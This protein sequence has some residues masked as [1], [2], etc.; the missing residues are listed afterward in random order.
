[1]ECPYCSNEL[2]CDDYYG[3]GIPGRTGFKK[4]GDIYKCRNEDCESE[5]FNYYFHTDCAGN[6]REG[7]PC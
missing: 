6:L 5:L 4:L 7:Y 1:M 2:D 3:L